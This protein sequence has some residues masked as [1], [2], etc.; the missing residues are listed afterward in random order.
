MIQSI[1]RL[2][3]IS[4]PLLAA[5]SAT[6]VPS[7]PQSIA[8][9]VP[10]PQSAPAIEAI[11][12]VEIEYGNFSREQLELALLSEFRGLRGDMPGAADGYYRL[13]MDT[14]D[15]GILRRAVEYAS[16]L[17]NARAMT[18]LAEQ[19]LSLEP[20]TL[21]PHLILGFQYLEQGQFIRA[22]PHYETVLELGGQVDFT[23]LSARTFNLENRQ[24]DVIIE[25]LTGVLENHPGESSVYY[26]LAQMHDQNGATELARQWL[27][28]AREQFGDNP[29]TILIDAQI[30]QNA[31]EAGL[32]EALLIEGVEQYPEHRLMRYSLAQL[33]VQNEKLAEASVQFTELLR[34]EPQ[35]LETLYSLALI[36]L[37]LEQFTM[38]EAQ[39]RD[40]LRAGHRRDEANYYL[41]Y[42]LEQRGETEQALFHYQQIQQRSNAFLTAQRQIMRLFVELEQFEAA[43]EWVTQQSADSGNL[44]PMFPALQVEA[45]VNAG[46]EQQ[47]AEALNK[48]LNRYP[49]DVDLLFARVLLNE[50]ADQH[51]QVEEDLRR[52]IA[53]NPED[54]RALNHLGYSLTVQT[55]RYQEALALIE[56]AIDISPDDP[57]I[58]DS[59]GWVQYK[60]GYL[61]DALYNLQRAYAAFPDPEVAAHLGEV[62]W[63]MGQQAEALFI[64]QQ[65]LE[66][67]PQSEHVLDAMQ[68]LT[69]TEQSE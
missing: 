6:Q 43:S 12:P 61:E 54:A 60:L 15:P 4:L 51:S 53:I 32:A 9:E 31:G 42:L 23:A 47:A 2:L 39:L 24:R 33:L 34:R 49:D 55:D 50:R 1:R 16:A 59:L 63:T 38:A 20:D 5:C 17:G 37:E 7:D 69:G 56:R 13:A 26:A 28:R 62:L 25:R 36:N 21:D 41:G 11:E 67:D 48:A 19:W 8:D 35:D 29:R 44:A 52:I 18:T 57:A 58:I 14:L 10:A 68:R 30:Y 22:L 45:L 3:L 64:W 65:G 66:T 40:L 27:T 46:Y